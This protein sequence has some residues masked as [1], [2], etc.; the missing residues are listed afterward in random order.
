MSEGQRGE[1][2]V[3]F[4]HHQNDAAAVR[5]GRAPSLPLYATRNGILPCGMVHIQGKQVDT[6]GAGTVKRG[7]A[8]TQGD[9][10]LGERDG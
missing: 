3:N 8:E 10:F 4:S 6:F 7:D 5:M 1:A 2:S 9:A